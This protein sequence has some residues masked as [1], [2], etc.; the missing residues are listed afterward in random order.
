MGQLTDTCEILGQSNV[1]TVGYLDESNKAS[2][3]KVT[4]ANGGLCE[5]SQ[6]PAEINQPR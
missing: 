6:N 4:Y 1:R 3:I 2:G 5:D